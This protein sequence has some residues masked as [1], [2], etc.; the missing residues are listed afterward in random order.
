MTSEELESNLKQKQER[1][2]HKQV[3][4]SQEIL[5]IFILYAT[6]TEYVAQPY[7]TL[8]TEFT[9]PS[10]FLLTICMLKLFPALF[11]NN[12]LLQL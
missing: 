11:K 3:E 8:N 7:F 9:F 2:R 1:K 5:S 4:V 6:H 12:A 10:A